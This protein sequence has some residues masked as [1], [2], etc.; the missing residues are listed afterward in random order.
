MIAKREWIPPQGEWPLEA[1][2]EFWRWK[3]YES[4]WWCGMVACGA[5]FY[6]RATPKDAGTITE[7]VHGPWIAWLEKHHKEWFQWRRMGIKRRKRLASILPRFFRKT[8]W[9]TIFSD[10]YDHLHD[11]DLS[12]AVGSEDENNA[13]RMQLSKRQIIMGEAPFAW[14]VWLYGSWRDDDRTITRTEYTHGYRQNTALADYSSFIFSMRAGVTSTHPDKID[15]DDPLS[16][17][18]I[19]DLLGWIETV[20]G[21]YT[22]S[23]P[24]LRTDGLFHLTTTRYRDNDIPGTFFPKEGIRSWS[25]MPSRNEQFFLTPDGEWDVYFLSAEDDNRESICPEIITTEQLRREEAT[26]P[27]KYAR[28]YLNEPGTGEHMAITMQQVEEC[29]ITRPP[30]E[31][32]TQEDWDFWRSLTYMVHWDTAFKDPETMGS[33]DETVY[34]VSGHDPRGNGNVYYIEGKG[35]NL[36]RIEDAAREQVELIQRYKRYG[37]RIARITDEKPTSKAGAWFGYLRSML[38]GAGEQ[39]PPMLELTRGRQ[40]KKKGPGS[41]IRIH[42]GY[43]VDGHVKIVRNAP[44]ASTMIAQAV[45]LGVT[46]HDDWIDAFSDST[47]PEVYQQMLI[48]GRRERDEVPVSPGDDLITGL[49]MAPR[50]PRALEREDAYVDTFPDF[51]E[52]GWND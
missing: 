8:L 19:R 38:A 20:N 2:R 32:W 45:R 41:R 5:A 39:S 14:F 7:R 15:F 17:D 43:W 47:H 37:M 36:W 21:A 12:T 25:G 29:M 49:S 9:V 51:A 11:P 40:S 22:T 34:V 1:E 24:A 16:E 18:K 28:Q 4:L 46:K 48:P 35:S 13:K 31:Q 33:G 44:G 27:I 26:D 50:R 6:M 10:I 30:M 3:C 52:D 23:R 42:L